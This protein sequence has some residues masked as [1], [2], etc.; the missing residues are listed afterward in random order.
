[1]VGQLNRGWAVAKRLLQHERSPISG[2]QPQTCPVAE[3]A[4]TCVTEV[5]VAA[6]SS[7]RPLHDT[8]PDA[9]LRQQVIEHEMGARAFTLTQ[10][11][12]RGAN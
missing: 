2:S 9:T 8:I 10:V 7:P 4:R 12:A 11:R 3:V 5:P 1:M 6:I